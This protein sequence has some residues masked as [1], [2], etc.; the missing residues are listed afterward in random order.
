VPVLRAQR[1]G[2]GLP[3]RTDPGDSIWLDESAAFAAAYR[4]AAPAA[5][6]TPFDSQPFVDHELIFVCRARLDDRAGLLQQLQIDSAQ[7]ATLSDSH[8]LRHC[9]K[10]GGRDAPA[11][12]LATSH[13]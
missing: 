7:G 11:R 1:D 4:P 12:L 9:Y 8:I 3:G 5:G 13:S 2:R 10:N 6:R